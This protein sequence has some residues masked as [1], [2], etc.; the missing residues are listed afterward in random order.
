MGELKS[1]NQSLL[2]Q[3][4]KRTLATDRDRIAELVQRVTVV[5]QALNQR[6]SM[7]PSLL[8]RPDFVRPAHCFQ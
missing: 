2:F 8:T 5:V 3:I 1:L 7:S 4:G 6:M